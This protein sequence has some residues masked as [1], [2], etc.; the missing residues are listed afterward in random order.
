MLAKL[1]GRGPYVALKSIRK[2]EETN[3]SNLATEAHV[4]KISTDCRVLCQ[5]Y[6]AFETQRHA[7]YV[8]EYL[9]GG[10]L[11]DEL[12]KH[13]RF[14]MDRVRFYSA[15][16]ICGLQFLHSKGIIH[17]DLKP[18]NILLDHDGHAVISDFGLAVQNI[19]KDDT[20]TGRVGTLRYMAPEMLQGKPYNAAVDWWSLGHTIYEMA[21]AD[22]L[23]NNSNIKEQMYSIILDE[24]KLPHWL[25][26]DLRHLLRKLLRKN[27]SQRL[28]ARGDIRCHPFF[29][30]IDWVVL[31]NEET[32]PPYKPKAVHIVFKGVI[33][34]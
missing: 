4:L 34:L 30:F 23:I 20:T 31:E 9:S 6:A 21:T 18:L 29:E 22:A 15:E 5:G 25:D 26:K 19:F 2:A 14:D 17:R 10:N 28:G 13:G 8:M 11:G 7:F 1:K 33:H 12:D 16:I 32:Q 27:P 3:Y 24:P